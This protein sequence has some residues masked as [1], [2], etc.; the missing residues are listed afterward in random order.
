MLF[1]YCPQ[2]PAGMEASWRRSKCHI[3][4]SMAF[5]WCR[6]ESLCFTHFCSG[7]WFFLIR[8]E[9]GAESVPWRGGW[10]ELG[11]EGKGSESA[12]WVSCKWHRF[13]G[14]ATIVILPYEIDTNLKERERNMTLREI[15]DGRY[16]NSLLPSWASWCMWKYTSAQA[17]LEN[18]SGAAWK[19]FPF[20]W[21]HMWKVLC[22]CLQKE[23]FQ[24]GVTHNGW[25]QGCKT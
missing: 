15:R 2:L 6:L 24:M 9:V 18:T 22:S 11:K 14:V 19:C 23:E 16:L 21:R 7:I 12:W 8:Q 13:L 25:W 5:P 3:S 20:R 10:S 4:R 1:R 17:A